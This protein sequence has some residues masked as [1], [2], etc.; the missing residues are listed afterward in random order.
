MSTARAV[1]LSSGSALPQWLEYGLP[2]V[3][4]YTA[5]VLM[6]GMADRMLAFRRERDRAQ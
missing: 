2:L 4:A 1:Q 5:V 3:L 6:L